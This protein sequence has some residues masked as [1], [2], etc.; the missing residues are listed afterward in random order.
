VGPKAGHRILSASSVPCNHHTVAIQPRPAPHQK[1]TSKVGQ[2][3]M[4]DMVTKS[5]QPCAQ[6]KLLV[7]CSNAWRSAYRQ[8]A[9]HRTLPPPPCTVYKLAR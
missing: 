1:R 5:G 4:R 8:L 2:D 9:L 7:C 3:G 6:H